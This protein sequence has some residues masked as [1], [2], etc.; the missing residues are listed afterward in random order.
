MMSCRSFH[1]EELQR[2]HFVVHAA[3]I[4]SCTVYTE[5]EPMSEATVWHSWHIVKCSITWVVHTAVIW[6]CTVYT[7]AEPMS[8]ATI[9]HSWHI[10]KCSIT[11]VVHTAVILSCTV[12]TE[13]EPMSEARIWHSWHTVKCSMMWTL[14]YL[15]ELK[16]LFL[17]LICPLK[18]SCCLTITHKF[19]NVL[20]RHFP[21]NIIVRKDHLTVRSIKKFFLIYYWH[22]GE[23]GSL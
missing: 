18:I 7:E 17:L 12:Y 2:M 10:V 9:W 13:A 1:G 21:D 8:E 16:T 11:W 23:C 19:K 5:A 22:G 3:A 6:S 20:C 14:L 4:W 15:C